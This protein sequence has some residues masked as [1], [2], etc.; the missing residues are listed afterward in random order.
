MLSIILMLE[1]ESLVAVKAYGKPGVPLWHNGLTI[2]C[3]LCSDSGGW[4]LQVGS[5]AGTFPHSVGTAKK[6]KKKCGK[7]IEKIMYK[8]LKILVLA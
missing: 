8:N 6:K 5:P 1:K 7:I 3:C 4:W 2:L